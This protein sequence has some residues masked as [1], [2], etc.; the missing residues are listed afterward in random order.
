MKHSA[1]LPR[2]ASS[3]QV[4]LHSLHCPDLT[5]ITAAHRQLRTLKITNGTNRVFCI[6]R[7]NQNKSNSSKNRSKCR[8]SA[9]GCPGPSLRSKDKT[10]PL[11]IIR[12]ASFLT[13][14]AGERA[15][16]GSGSLGSVLRGGSG[17]SVVS[18]P[19]T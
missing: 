19:W 12:A 1:Q 5:D 3:T 15:L 8:Y 14:I 13:A 7:H 16:W 17:A 6:T 18:R 10:S 2:E 11:S 4:L 9:A